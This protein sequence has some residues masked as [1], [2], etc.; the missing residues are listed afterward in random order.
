MLFKKI[1]FVKLPESIFLYKKVK[2]GLTN[3]YCSIQDGM[4]VDELLK[5]RPEQLK[6]HERDLRSPKK[7]HPRR[8]TSPHLLTSVLCC[9]IGGAAMTETAGA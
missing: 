7:A 4:P 5:Q 2:I 6:T 1:H 8:L 9:G 3:L